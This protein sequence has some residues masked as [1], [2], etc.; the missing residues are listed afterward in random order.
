MNSFETQLPARLRLA[1]FSG[2]ASPLHPAEQ[3]TSPRAAAR[4]KFHPSYGYFLLLLILTPIYYRTLLPGL[5]YWGDSAKYQFVGKVLGTVHLP[6][7]PLYLLLNHL[8]VTV[9][10]QGTLAFRVNL[11][12]LCFSL[13]ALLIFYNLLL[14]LRIRPLI[15]FITA[16]IFA[17]TYTFWLFALVAEVYSLHLLLMVAVINLMLRWRASRQERYFYAGC[18]LYAVS[19]GNHQAMAALLPSLVYLV[20]VTDRQTFWNPR[21]IL[22][23][24][25]FILL[26]LA[27]YLYVPWRASDPTTAFL[28]SRTAGLWQYAGSLGVGTAFHL[29]FADL[30]TGRLP[31]AAGFFWKNFLLLLPL[32]VYGVFAVKD[33]QLNVFLLLLAAVNT[34]LVLQLDFSEADGL[35]LPAFLVLAIYLGFAFEA[36]AARW[37]LVYRL[38]WGLLLIPLALLLINYRQVDQSNRIQHALRVEKMI[39]VIQRDALVIADDYEY[40]AYFWYYLIGEGLGE[41]DLY[42]LPDYAIHSEAVKNYLAGQGS[43]K[44]PAQQQTLPP[45]LDVYIMASIASKL[46]VPGLSL[47]PTGSKYLY[48]VRL[49]SDTGKLPIPNAATARFLLG[50]IN[51]LPGLQQKADIFP[52][53]IWYFKPCTCRV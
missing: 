46:D 51:T 13:A 20:W 9:V 40:A 27:L 37:A 24:A 6:G 10:P 30:V 53:I 34:I 48:R 50:Q 2:P 26:G 19:F 18:L 52:G 47:E 29:G 36:L 22:T 35:Y 4:L 3:G 33:R 8:F 49:S 32:A 39:S 44:L 45:G 11:L 21:K 14:F 23:V 43:I 42:A 16:L 12:S 31:V 28:E 1:W 15:A 41:R 17:L 5:G 25:A 38:A 7:N